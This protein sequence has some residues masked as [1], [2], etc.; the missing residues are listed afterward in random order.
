MKVEMRNMIDD[1][2]KSGVDISQCF[3]YIRRQYKAFLEYRKYCEAKGYKMTEDFSV[4]PVSA[5]EFAY[6]ANPHFIGLLL[7]LELAQPSQGQW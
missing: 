6:F 7:S 5:T 1:F 4:V 3:D 2:K